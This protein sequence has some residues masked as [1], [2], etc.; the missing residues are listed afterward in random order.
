MR[1]PCVP[2]SNL[3]SYGSL[4]SSLVAI[5]GYDPV[6]AFDNTISGDSPCTA[7]HMALAPEKEGCTTDTEVSVVHKYATDLTEIREGEGQF[8]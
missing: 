7:L 1:F 8:A 4:L 3:H 2:P 5:C 6:T